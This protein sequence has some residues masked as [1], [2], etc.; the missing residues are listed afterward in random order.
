MHHCQS[1]CHV[2][3]LCFTDL[4]F[5]RFI[6][7]NMKPWLLGFR[8][9][10]LT[11]TQDA[12][13][14]SRLRPQC[15]QVAN[16]TK[17]RCLNLSDVQLVPPPGEFDETYALSTCLCFDD[18]FSPLRENMKSSTSE[19]E[20]NDVLY[21]RRKGEP[22]PHVTCTEN[23]VKCWRVVFEIAS[24]ETD[25]YTDTLIATL[26][27]LPEAKQICLTATRHKY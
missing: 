4:Y 20:V 2:S 14:N 6:S 3:C 13:G 11:I 5:S 27:T 16:S 19:P 21:Y 24:G 1:Y 22:Q 23:L 26:C 25:R 12:V 10:A 18:L 9:S 7:S 17:Q 8:C 15:R